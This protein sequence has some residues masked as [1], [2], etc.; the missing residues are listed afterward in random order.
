MPYRSE[1]GPLETSA[2]RQGGARCLRSARPLAALLAGVAGVAVFAAIAASAAAAEPGDAKAR[3]TRYYLGFL[4]AGSWVTADP[5]GTGVTPGSDAD[6]SFFWG[7]NLG[8]QMPIFHDAL[9]LRLELEGTNERKLNFETPGGTNGYSTHIEAWT[10]QG[11]FWFVYPLKKLWPDTPVVNRISPFGGGGVGLSRVSFDTVN[12]GVS[13]SDKSVRFA[14]QGGVGLSFDVVR[15]LT[16]DLR[17][18][19]ID[20]GKASV[21]LYDGVG[22]PSG[23]FEVDLGGHELVGGLR[24]VY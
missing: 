18:Q 2:R 7:A 21:P 4:T 8:T 14:W 5:S 10:F 11:N 19:Y 16:L 22:T 23:D 17:Y 20:L 3:S 13:G 9:D 24:F 12:G 6:H 15:W 1:F